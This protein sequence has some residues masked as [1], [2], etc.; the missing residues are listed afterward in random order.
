MFIQKT[1]WENRTM[2][3]SGK[4]RIEIHRGNKSFETTSNYN[5]AFPLLLCARTESNHSTLK[6]RVFSPGSLSSL[7]KK[8]FTELSLGG[9]KSKTGQ[10]ALAGLLMGVERGP[11]ELEHMP[12]LE[13]KQRETWVPQFF[14][15]A[16]SQWPK[17]HSLAAP[18]KGVPSLIDTQHINHN[19]NKMREF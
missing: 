19:S 11:S 2:R 10:A 4:E 3:S 17:D 6:L 1:L 5:S 18:A 13:L 15:R 12:H 7:L 14:S 8:M 16:H 9:L